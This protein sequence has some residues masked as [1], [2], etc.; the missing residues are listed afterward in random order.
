MVEKIEDLNLP[1]SVVG[2]IIKDALPENAV[3]SK[4]S[5]N[6]LTRAASVFILWDIKKNL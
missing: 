6:A 4:E 2:R 1:V 5:K 3:C